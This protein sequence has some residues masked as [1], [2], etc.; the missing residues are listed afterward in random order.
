MRE[1]TFKIVSGFYE[2]Q[3]LLQMQFLQNM[4]DQVVIPEIKTSTCRSRNPMT[5]KTRGKRGNP[6]ASGFCFPDETIYGSRC[7]ALRTGSSVALSL[8]I[9]IFSYTSAISGRAHDVI[10]MGTYIGEARGPFSSR[11][12]DGYSKGRHRGKQH[13]IASSRVTSATISLNGIAAKHFL[14]FKKRN[15]NSCREV[16]D[17]CLQSEFI[18]KIYLQKGIHIGHFTIGLVKANYFPNID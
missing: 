2:D 1:I 12:R 8:H 11:V 10:T 6:V 4:C 15:G 7:V 3:S 5:T 17:N 9:S 18:C 14:L 13:E 16:G